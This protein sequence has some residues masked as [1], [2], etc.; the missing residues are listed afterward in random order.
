MSATFTNFKTKIVQRI[1]NGFEYY[2][3]LLP[4]G[5]RVASGSLEHCW[6]ERENWESV[7]KSK[8]VQLEL[9]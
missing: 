9:F 6:D 8:P 3:L 1:Q 7:L 2:E 5:R 4:D